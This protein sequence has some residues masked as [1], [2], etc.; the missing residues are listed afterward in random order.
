V[1]QQRDRIAELEAALREARRVI[2]E[3]WDRCTKG[4]GIDVMKAIDAALTGSAVDREGVK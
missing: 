3:D 4:E 2:W 1:A